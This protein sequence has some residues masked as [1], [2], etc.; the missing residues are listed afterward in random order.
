MG[1]LKK[2]SGSHVGQV[3]ALNDKRKVYDTSLKQSSII[4]Y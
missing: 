4:S 2:T 3:D 1:I